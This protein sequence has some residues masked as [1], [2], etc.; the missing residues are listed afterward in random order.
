MKKLI[1]F[2]FL[3]LIGCEKVYNRKVFDDDNK[4]KN[5]YEIKGDI[6]TIYDYATNG[7]LMMKLKFKQDQFIDTIYYYDFKNH[8]ITIDSSKGKY[9]YG[10]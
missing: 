7:K 4:L 1:I 9:Y 10:T 3:S 2:V 8:F 5:V 6:I